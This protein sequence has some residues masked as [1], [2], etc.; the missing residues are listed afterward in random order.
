MIRQRARIKRSFPIRKR[1]ARKRQRT[2]ERDRL[3]LAW[4]HTHGCL[5]AGRRSDS[6]CS[7]YL[8]VH[9]L[10]HIK[11]P[12]GRIERTGRL[13]KRTLAL[14]QGHHQTGP[15][16]VH[17]MTGDYGLEW[18]RFFEVDSER[19][20]RRYNAIFNDPDPEC[21]CRFTGD[22]ADASGC[23]LHGV[24]RPPAVRLVMEEG[25]SVPF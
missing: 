14:C 7:G 1:S 19:E 11:H 16:A 9:H 24:S 8:T 23:H 17:V 5:V 22:R 20:I 18:E 25:E 12:D 15:H 13:D 6:P 21:E 2:D 3:F 4:M 10:R